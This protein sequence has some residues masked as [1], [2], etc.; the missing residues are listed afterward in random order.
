MRGPAEGEEGVRGEVGEDIELEFQGESG[1]GVGGQ[2]EASGE[3]V[4]GQYEASRDVGKAVVL[5][6]G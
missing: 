4:G 2:H 3:G 6:I 1:E 5:G